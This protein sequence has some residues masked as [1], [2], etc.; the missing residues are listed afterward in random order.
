MC[1]TA[2]DRV[3]AEDLPIFGKLPKLGE[4]WKLQAQGKYADSWGWVVMTDAKSGDLLS[5]AAH[6]LGPDGQPRIHR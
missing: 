2:G 1:F 4:N 3:V 6:R 5:F